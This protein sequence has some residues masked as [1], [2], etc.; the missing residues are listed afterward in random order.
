MRNTYLAVGIIVV[1]LVIVAFTVV[2]TRLPKIGNFGT[3]PTPT[4]AVEATGDKDKKDAISVSKHTP[5]STAVVDV[6]TLQKPGFVAI[7][8]NVDGQP[9]QILGTSSLLPAGTHQNI[10]IALA[11]KTVSGESLFAQVYEDNGDGLFQSDKDQT[12]KDESGRALKAQFMVS[13]ETSG[14]QIPATG[15]GEGDR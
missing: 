12:V 10:T 2:R 9:G 7:V 6:V 15:L 14:F 4:P 5:A 13:S 11:R 1:I 3:T 8:E